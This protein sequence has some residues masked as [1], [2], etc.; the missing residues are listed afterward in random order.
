MAPEGVS[1]HFARMVAHGPTGTLEGQEER[2]RTQ[3]KH[4]GE[5]A[6]LLA[7]VKPD[8]IM[9][10]HTATSYTL[11]RQAEAELVQRLQNQC[12]TAV[13]TAFG[14]VIAALK[15]LGVTRVALGTPYS[16]ETTLKG[17]ALLEAH[18]LEVVSHGRLQNV[19]NIYDE[20]PERAHQLGRGKTKPA[21]AALATNHNGGLSRADMIA[22]VLR[23]HPHRTVRELIALLDREYH[24]KTTESAVTGHLY[25]RREKFVHTP[26]DHHRLVTW[27]LK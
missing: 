2:N 26:P 1:V 15:V 11:G 25:T 16:E 18:G 22:A 3:I 24:W 8:V 4:I 20:T 12:G 21:R 23:R 5:S 9:L 13:A 27:S 17:K 10:A 6:A 14:S 19:T 7:M